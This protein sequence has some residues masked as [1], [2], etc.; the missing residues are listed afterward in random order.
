[1]EQIKAFLEEIQSNEELQKELKA[2]RKKKAGIAE[3]V[4]LARQ[5]GFSFTEAELE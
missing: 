4:A 1:M 5:K 3:I 2:L